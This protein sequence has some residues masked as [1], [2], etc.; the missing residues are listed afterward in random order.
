M[1]LELS[2]KTDLAIK[3]LVC[4]SA[5]DE[6]HPLG[7]RNLAASIGTSTH[8]LPQVMSPLVRATWVRSIPGPGGG[9]SIQLSVDDISVLDVVDAIEGPIELK[10]CV[11]RGVPCPA[12][13]LCVL[14]YPWNRARDALLAELDAT[15]LTEVMEP[16]ST[17]E[18]G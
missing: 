15:P 1:R 10:Q 6:A 17:K 4:L 12:E 8:L 13:E 11:L 2:K 7:G 3:A 16:C 18:G 5:F 9:Y 14:H